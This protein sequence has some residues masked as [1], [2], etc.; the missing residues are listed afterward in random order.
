MHFQL[1]Q[2]LISEP[3]LMGLGLELCCFTGGYRQEYGRVDV[4]DLGL[5]FIEC[6]SRCYHGAQNPH[7]HE[8]VT[9]TS[10]AQASTDR[11]LTLNQ[12]LHCS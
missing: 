10:K 2:Q 11:L 3:P 5:D 4:P 9:P 8:I 6:Y 12:L 7:F 1:V